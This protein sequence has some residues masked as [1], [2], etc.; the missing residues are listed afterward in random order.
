MK[1]VVL[2][3]LSFVIVFALVPLTGLELSAKAA[4]TYTDGYYTYSVSN[5]NAT[6]TSVDEAASGD[7]IVPETLGIS[8]GY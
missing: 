7:I 2:A 6:I 8:R 5:G 1:K 3:L 4:E